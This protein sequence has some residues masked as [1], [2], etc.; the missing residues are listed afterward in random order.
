MLPS[1]IQTNW[2]IYVRDPRTG[3]EGVHFITNAIDSTVHAIAA[4]M[5]SEGMPMHALQSAA[6]AVAEGHVILE[7]SPGS[8]TAPDARAELTATTSAPETGPWSEVF[9]SYREML[10]YTV[11]QDRAL[12]A[13]HGQDYIARQEIR[14][15][16]PIDSCEPLHGPVVSKMAAVL[17]GDAEPFCFR[18]AGV[19][20][21][22]DTEERD[23]FV[24]VA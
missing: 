9:A 7:L 5:L 16:I 6:L 10:A 22:F 1:P 20:F 2:R 12:S 19:R 13:D 8:G 18:I 15:D 23:A 4:R 3:K 21:R 14:L 17:V 11:P 24:P